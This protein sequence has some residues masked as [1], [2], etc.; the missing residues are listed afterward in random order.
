MTLDTFFD[1]LE[2]LFDEQD[3]NETDTVATIYRNKNGKVCEIR[4]FNPKYDDI[5]V[6]TRKGEIDTI[7]VDEYKE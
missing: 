3:E 5:M 2:S 1:N 4:V 6:I 7:T